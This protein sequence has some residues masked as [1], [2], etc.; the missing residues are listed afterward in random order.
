MEK[1]KIS[2][3]LNLLLPSQTGLDC[4]GATDWDSQSQIHGQICPSQECANPRPH[5]ATLFQFSE[6]SEIFLNVK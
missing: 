1:R 3:T 5:I 6:F 4:A 2:E